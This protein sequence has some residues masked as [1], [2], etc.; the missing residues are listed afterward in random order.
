MCA[1]HLPPALCALFAPPPA[2]LHGAWGIGRVLACH[3]PGRVVSF[4]SGHFSRGALTLLVAAEVYGSSGPAR[5]V[6]L[7]GCL[8]VPVRIRC[9]SVAKTAERRRHRCG[10]GAEPVRHRCGSRA[11]RVR[12]GCGTPAERRRICGA[13][14]SVCSHE[15]MTQSGNPPLLCSFEWSWET[16]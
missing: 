7:P 11:E 8:R 4:P 10:T 2:Y 14:S 3:P 15:V 1:W 5:C 16:N 12:N 13:A 9:G 6:C